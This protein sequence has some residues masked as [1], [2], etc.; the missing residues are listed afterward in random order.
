MEVVTDGIMFK[1]AEM[2]AND[3]LDAEA[4]RVNG[5]D[6]GNSTLV[7]LGG[8]RVRVELWTWRSRG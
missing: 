4:G 5:E 8:E 6:E 7:P 1:V 2:L 3:V